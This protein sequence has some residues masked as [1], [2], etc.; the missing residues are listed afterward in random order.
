MDAVSAISL[1]ASII[2]FVDFSSKLVKGS[3]EVYKSADGMTTNDAHI[4]TVLTDLRSVTATLKSNLKGDSLN[5]ESLRQ[6]AVSCADASRELSD[7]IE[8]LKVKE[9]NPMWKSVEAKWKSMTK[10]KEL[11]SLDQRLN[12]Y[13]LQV[14]IRLNLI[15][16]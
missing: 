14:I 11:A 9:G 8:D 5:H 1:A 4:N 12:G 7:I 3:Y 15:M 10:S 6:L 13:R 2:T 16:R